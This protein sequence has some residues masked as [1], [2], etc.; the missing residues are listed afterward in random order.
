MVIWGSGG[1]YKEFPAVF[2]M[3]GTKKMKRCMGKPE[4]LEQRKEREKRVYEY[5]DRLGIE[6][7]RVDHEAAMTMEACLEV[8]QVLGVKMCKNLFL[9]NRQKTSFYLLMMPGDKVFKTKELS[10]Q[11]GSARLSFASEEYMVEY[12]DLYPGAVSVMGLM[13]D[14]E[15]KVQLLIDEEVLNEEYVGCHPCVNTASL[16]IRTEDL[17]K[18]YLPAVH[19]EMRVVN[20]IGEE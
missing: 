15:N 16:K 14:K 8:D 17:V 10:A 3:K 13:N 2:L 4:D 6:Y 9:C 12:L 1:F 19:H 18:N 20:L 5:L 7:E 11:I